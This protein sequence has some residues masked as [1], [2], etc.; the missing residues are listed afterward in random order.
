MEAG[1]EVKLYVYDLTKGLAS[2]MSMALLG[3]HLDGIWHTSIVIFGR[4]YFYGGGG[5]ESCK[6]RGTILGQPEQVHDMGSTQVDYGLWLEYLGGLGS[7]EFCG[8]RYNLFEHNCN[9]FSNEVCQFLTGNSIPAFILTLPHEVMNTPIGAMMKGLIE[10]L[11]SNPTGRP[12]GGGENSH[13]PAYDPVPLPSDSDTPAPPKPSTENPS[14]STTTKPEV[15]NQNPTA[16]AE[17]SASQ[18]ESKPS[19]AASTE[20]AGARPTQSS[21]D[22]GA[23]Q[24]KADYDSD[25]EFIEKLKMSTPMEPLRLKVYTDINVLACVET[26]EKKMPEGLLTREEMK[27]IL[28]LKDCVCLEYLMEEPPSPV[29]SECFLVIG[30]L[31]N[32]ATGG[33]PPEVLHPLVDLLQM[34]FLSQDVI[35][36]LSN[37]DDHTIMKFVS[38]SDC[39]PIQ[40]QLSVFRMLCNICSSY[41]GKLW[42]TQVRHWTTDD[43]G[44]QSNLESIN[45]LVVYGILS[46]SD[47]LCCAASALVYNLTRYQVSDDSAVEFSSALL[48]SLTSETIS[49]ETAYYNLLALYGLMKC[50]EVMCLATVMGLDTIRYA[51][52]SERLNKLCSDID[53]VIG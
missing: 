46:G 20:E 19:A 27:L 18:S 8:E 14:T 44:Q 15:T 5:I 37:N 35:H 17:A 47:E 21:A 39:Q 51:K 53:S 22:A 6:P 25:D 40:I 42:L 34:A 24:A 4:E 13:R 50:G 30:K 32:L 28:E 48:Q 16:Q 3:T 9:T 36:T 49:E 52:V 23:P 10:S 38:S 26:I 11:S 7:D 12:I 33:I 29:K 31:L 2:T 1:N 41:Q 43:G 45:R